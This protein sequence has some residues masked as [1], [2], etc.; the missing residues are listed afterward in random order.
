MKAQLRSELLKLRTTRASTYLLLA[1]AGLVAVAVALHAVSLPAARL[2]GSD[3][4]LK[5]LGMG[6]TFGM[7]FASLLGAMSLTSE[8]RHGLIRPTLL[9]TPERSQVLTAK[10]LIAALAGTVVGLIAELVALGVAT[11]GL[12]ARGMDLALTGAQRAQLLTGGAA[13]AALWAALGVGIGALV[14]NQVISL[15]GVAIWL[16]FVEQTLAGIIPSA[17]QFAP[18]AAAGSLAGA[19]L[20]Q[21]SSTLL[22]PAFGGLV[23]VG[24]LLLISAGAILAFSRRDVG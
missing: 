6:T 5:I 24:Y 18:G 15:V 9:V 8:I 2:Q 21:T 12:A 4:Q 3:Q 17:A 11:A 16:L 7:L 10:L 1:V 19:I 14:R 20:Q 13:A 23:I 22:A